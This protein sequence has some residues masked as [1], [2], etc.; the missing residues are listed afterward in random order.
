MGSPSSPFKDEI[1]PRSVS[2][3]STI[4]SELLA[5]SPPKM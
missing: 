1:V 2:N 4:S 3:T 5:T